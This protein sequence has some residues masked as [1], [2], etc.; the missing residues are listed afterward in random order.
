MELTT[1]F[2]DKDEMCKLL[3]TLE[4]DNNFHRSVL[5][6][7]RYPLNFE[8]PRYTHKQIVALYKYMVKNRHDVPNWLLERWLHL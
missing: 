4:K 8:Y 7:L 6:N 5:H 3:N 2:V 1:V